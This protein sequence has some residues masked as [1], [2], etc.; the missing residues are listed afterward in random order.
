MIGAEG[1]DAEGAVLARKTWRTLEPLHGIIYFVP[2]AADAYVRL[3]IAGQA[4]YFAS[5]AAPS[6][7]SV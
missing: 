3:G 7:N 5:R 2:E 4:G 6:R 1:M